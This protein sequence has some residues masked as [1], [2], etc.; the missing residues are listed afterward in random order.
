MPVITIAGN[1]GK[2]WCAAF[3]SKEEYEK[4]ASSEILSYFIDAGLKMILD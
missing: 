3:T 1:D 4:G 2:T